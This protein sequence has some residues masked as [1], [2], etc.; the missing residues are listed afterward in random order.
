MQRRVRM[1]KVRS[2]LTGNQICLTSSAYRVYRSIRVLTIAYVPPFRKSLILYIPPSLP[3]RARCPL[4]TASR[5]MAL[6]AF[7]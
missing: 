7:R 3:F 4:G 6:L 2:A 1:E 5:A